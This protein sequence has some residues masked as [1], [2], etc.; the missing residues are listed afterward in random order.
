MKTLLLAIGLVVG[1]AAQAVVLIDDFAS[2]PYSKVMGAGIDKNI[3]VGTML[4]GDRGTYLEVLA[5]PLN[6]QM[7]FNVGNGYLIG[8][9]GSQLRDRVDVMYGVDLIAG[10]FVQ[11]DM[12][13]NLIGEDRIRLGFDS[14]DLDL[15][16]TLAVRSG[17]N[18]Y[19]H[20]RL[21]AGGR[22]NTP[23]DED[24]MF[25]D[26]GLAGMNWADVDEIS[27]KFRNNPSGDFALNRL[28]AVPEPASILAL[29]AG[30]AMVIR[31]RRKGQKS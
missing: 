19:T 13:A 22:A 16:M 6:V 5:N 1:S 30:L 18:T 20:S 11:S 12:N 8:D 4:G 31:K 9:A 17:A 14:N 15:N 25:T 24:V 2:G 26:A 29:G 3:Q 27:V 21:I 28:E 10:T 7:E 23:F